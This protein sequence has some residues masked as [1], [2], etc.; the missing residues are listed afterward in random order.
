MGII[1]KI[2]NDINNKIYIGKTEVSLANRWASHV[3]EQKKMR[4]HG[5]SKI[6]DAMRKYGIEHFKIEK[7]E[8]YPN[9][10]LNEREKYWIKTLNTLDDSFGYNISQGG[11]GKTLYNKELIKELWDKGYNGLEIRNIVGCSEWTLQ[12]TLNLF[13]IPEFDRRKRALL[14]IPYDKRIELVNQYKEGKCIE[15][16]K[17][18][19]GYSIKSIRHVL[20]LNGITAQQRNRRVDE[21]NSKKVAMCD[22]NTWEIIKV[23]NSRAEAAKYVNGDASPICSGIKGGGIRYGY[24]WKNIE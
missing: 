14:V 21:I 2:T 22:P 1:Y 3:C 18:E 24:H 4:D 23:F 5:R 8:E 9:D 17:R 15:Q 19:Y 13:D 16:L 11:E 7:I 12:Q 10:Q 20:D 6:H